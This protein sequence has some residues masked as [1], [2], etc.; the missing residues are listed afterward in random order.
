M[1]YAHFCISSLKFNTIILARVSKVEIIYS[2]IEFQV[3]HAL[4]L[5]NFDFFLIFV[6]KLL[7]SCWYICLKSPMPPP[8]SNPWLCN[9]FYFKEDWSLKFYWKLSQFGS[10]K[11]Y[12]TYH[13]HL[14]KVT[15]RQLEGRRCLILPFWADSKLSLTT[16]QLKMYCSIL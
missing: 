4:S 16:D 8:L 9:W 6:G 7:T 15:P 14:P 1:W 12:C 10:S 11:T 3:F 2:F 5:V 13:W